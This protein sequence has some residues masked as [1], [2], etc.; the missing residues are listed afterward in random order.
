MCNYSVVA[1]SVPQSCINKRLLCPSLA[2]TLRNPILPKAVSKRKYVGLDERNFDEDAE[3]KRP[4]AGQEYDP[5]GDYIYDARKY[6]NPEKYR[7]IVANQEKKKQKQ[8]ELEKNFYYKPFHGQR[9]HS[10]IGSG[11]LSV[12]YVDVGTDEL[13]SSAAS[14]QRLQ[15]CI[16][17][18]GKLQNDDSRSSKRHKKT[19]KKPK[20]SKH[21][22]HSHTSNSA[23]KHS[24]RKKGDKKK[25]KKKH[26]RKKH[27][28][29]CSISLADNHDMH[30]HL[31]KKH[32]AKLRHRS[33]YHS[34]LFSSQEPCSAVMKISRDV[35][36][37]TRNLE[38]SVG[39]VRDNADLCYLTDDSVTSSY[40]GAVYDSAQNFGYSEDDSSVYEESRA[41]EHVAADV[42]SEAGS[43][44]TAYSDDKGNCDSV[45]WRSNRS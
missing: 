18:D 45:D 27:S 22:S 29:T 39:N 30:S 41:T 33:Q 36:H 15:Y 40:H 10:N 43:V 16:D 42:R 9:R 26:K 38:K 44:S 25:H 19:K 7:E 24:E 5:D 1:R 31:S 28:D 34:R 32:R 6:F 23:H 3:K 35:S 11:H 8:Q 13:G 4:D 14:L 12:S 21:R 17:D 2:S 37:G 20:H